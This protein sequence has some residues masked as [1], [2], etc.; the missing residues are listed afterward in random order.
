MVT[1]APALWAR[2]ADVMPRAPQP[3][4]ATSRGLPAM[5][6]PTAIVL[7]PHAGALPAWLAPVQV[8]VAP[9]AP[10][11]QAAAEAAADEL[12]AAGV[13]VELDDRRE[14]LARRVAEAHAHGVP[15]LAVIGAREASR[16]ALTLRIRDEQQVLPRAQAVARIVRDCA[17]PV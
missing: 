10:A 2:M 11:Q 17:P 7:E 8:V 5:A 9:V 13:R 4:T 16:E 12:R 3:T 1:L 6:L 14:P 15:M